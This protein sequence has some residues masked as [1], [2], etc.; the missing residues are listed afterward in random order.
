MKV[1]SFNPS[2]ALNTIAATIALVS[3]SLKIIMDFTLVL[4]I[5]L[6]ILSLIALLPNGIF[7]F[8]LRGALVFIAAYISSALFWTSLYAVIVFKRSFDESDL[9]TSS[10]TVVMCFITIIMIVSVASRPS[11]RN[12]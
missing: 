7:N 5:L 6:D 4:L 12:D 8:R 10:A 3:Y 2:W 1:T 9:L 11:G